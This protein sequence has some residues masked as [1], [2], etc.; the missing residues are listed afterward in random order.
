[1]LQFESIITICGAVITIAG[2]LFT[3]GQTKKAKNYSE[4]IKVDVEK[5]SLMKISESLYRCQ[6]EVRRLPRDRNKLPRGYKIND[7][8]DKIWPHFDHI[9][10]SHVLSGNNSEARKTI[11]DAQDLLRAYEKNCQPSVDPYQIQC[12]LQDSLSEIS[13]K[14][15]KLEGKA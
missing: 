2:A 13:A 15:Y 6:E 10:S 3:L 1:M 7:A 14:I 9:L 8:L 12:L 4:Q 11:S 5:L